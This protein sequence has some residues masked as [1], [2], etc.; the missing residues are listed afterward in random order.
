MKP[1]IAVIGGGVYGT[2]VIKTYHTAHKEGLADFVAVCDINQKVLDELEKNYGVKGYLDYKEM[3]AQEELDG[4]AIVTPDYLHKQIAN[5]CAEQG[6]HMLVQKPLDTTTAGAMEMVETANKNNVMM[7]VDFHKR[8]DPG[9]I[10]LKNDIQAGRLGKIQYGY[11]CMEDIILVPSVWFK[12]WAQH[13]SPVWFLG[14]HF[15]DLIYWLIRS[16]PVEVYATGV[17]HKL[18]SMGIDTYDSIQ[19]KF[20]FENGEAFTVDASWILPNSFTAVVNQQIRVVGSEGMEE[21]D[22]QDRGLMAAFSSSASAVQANPYGKL[23]V[24]DMVYGGTRLMGYTLDSMI[25]FLKLL[26]LVKEGTPLQKLKPLYPTGE[27]AVVS[28]RMCEAVHESVES[29]KIVRIDL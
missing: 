16:K 18:K 12:T 8:Y 29:G 15:Y 9:H 25:H 24:E 6:V 1:K 20:K 17:K 11:V 2:Q 13:S 4:V 28:T 5:H 21:V 10:Q 23:E 3:L 26:R 22:S 7:F 14:V 27:E 19:A